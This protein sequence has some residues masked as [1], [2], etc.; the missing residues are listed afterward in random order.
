MG[1]NNDVG[2][3][4]PPRNAVVVRQA[5]EEIWNQGNLDVADV[6]FTSTYVNAG[7]LVPDVVRGPEAIKLAAALHHKAF[8]QLHVT[9]ERLISEGALVAFQWVARN[10]AVVAGVAPDLKG[11]RGALRGTTFCR[12]ASG[13]IVESWTSWDSGSVLRQFVRAASLGPGRVSV[14]PNALN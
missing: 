10:Q 13:R 1:E 12:L 3:M 7:G 11:P 6:L 8:P 9:I 4:S 2:E 5:I 14:R